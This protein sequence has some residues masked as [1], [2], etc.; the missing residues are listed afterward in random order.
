[1]PPVH[2]FR[3]V[4]LARH[5][6]FAAGASLTFWGEAFVHRRCVIED[7]SSRPALFR[8]ALSTRRT[9]LAFRLFR[10]W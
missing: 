8:R 6:F 2:T 5:T 10:A 4:T 3:I 1:M 7:A 9:T